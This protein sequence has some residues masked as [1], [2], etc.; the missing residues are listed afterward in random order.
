MPLATTDYTQAHSSEAQ[1]VSVWLLYLPYSSSASEQDRMIHIK[2]LLKKE[3]KPHSINC[4]YKDIEKRHLDG[5]SQRLA[6]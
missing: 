3:T 4:R 6:N 1:V 5:M 2:Q